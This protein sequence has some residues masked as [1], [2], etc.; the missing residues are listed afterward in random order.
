MD[1]VRLLLELAARLVAASDKRDWSALAE[2]DRALA[3]LAE[4]LA[5][6]AGLSEAERDALARARAAPRIASQR[7]AAESG[8][9]AGVLESLRSHREGWV[10]YALT[11]EWSE[12]AS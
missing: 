2:A 3:G 4:R 8:R 12:A 1:N 6:Q 10:A 9:L 7:C 5:A 11:E